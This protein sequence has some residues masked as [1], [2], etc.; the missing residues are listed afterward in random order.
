MRWHGSD[1]RSRVVSVVCVLVV[2]AAACSGDAPKSAPVNQDTLIVRADAQA[3]AGDAA[4]G[5]GSVSPDE[6]AVEGL[7]ADQTLRALGAQ[8]IAACP[9]AEANDAVARERCA[10]ALTALPLLRE[11]V[12]DPVLWGGQPAGL[13]LERVPEEAHLTFFNPRVWRRIYLSTLMFEE[14]TSIERAGRYDVLRV[15]VRFRNALDAG[16]YPYPFWHA[17]K[18]WASYEQATHLVFLFEDGRLIASVRSEQLDRARP[19]QPRQWDGAWTW[20]AGGEPR[21][22]LYRALFSPDNPF[23]VPLEERYRELSEGL[24]EHTCTGCHSPDNPVMMKHLDL[25][26]YPNQSLSGRHRIVTMI[27][28]NQMPPGVGI[29][30]EVKRTL[31]LERA[32]AFASVGDQALSFEGEASISAAPSGER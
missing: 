23:V 12:A 8:L 1:A 2:A 3:P 10:D 9:V 11:V 16:D 27:E 20:E 30:D 32:R 14:P 29:P 24:R 18:K 6:S 22:T 21:A 5:S 15:P 17:E 7:R 26:N 19:H 31:L 28:Q 13:A 4:L 25:L